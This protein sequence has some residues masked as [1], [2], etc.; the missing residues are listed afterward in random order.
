MTT[1]IQQQTL[2]I[3]HY[4]TPYIYC[5]SWVSVVQSG[6]I[7]S[8]ITV[9][10]TSC[11]SQTRCDRETTADGESSRAIPPQTIQRKH[12]RAHTG[13]RHCVLH[14]GYTYLSG[15]RQGLSEPKSTNVCFSWKYI[16]LRH[17]LRHLISYYNNWRKIGYIFRIKIW[18]V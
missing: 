10:P 4:I 17:Q 12:T 5:Q 1:V 18:L 15:H 6:F 8:H 7:S 13:W 16:V 2:Y 11:D 9:S 14:S 3:L